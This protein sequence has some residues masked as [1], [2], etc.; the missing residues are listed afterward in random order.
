LARLLRPRYDRPSDG[1]TAEERDQIAPSHHP[2]PGKDQDPYG[3]KLAHGNRA[4][5]GD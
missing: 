2:H 4:G 1:R 5:T 3:I